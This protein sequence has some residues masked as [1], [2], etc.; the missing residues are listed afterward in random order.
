MGI[1]VL[2]KQYSAHLSTAFIF[3]YN[4][5]DGYFVL[6][7]I[8]CNLY[9]LGWETKDWNWWACAT[10]QNGSAMH[11]RYFDVIILQQCCAKLIS[12]YVSAMS[13]QTLETINLLSDNV[14]TCFSNVSK[15]DWHYN[16]KNKK[17]IL[18]LNRR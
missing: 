14:H 11:V 1:F 10:D 13:C 16:A 12:E 9:P 17:Y 7:L 15:R 5:F 3:R 4:C 6:Y 2:L 8:Y 18:K